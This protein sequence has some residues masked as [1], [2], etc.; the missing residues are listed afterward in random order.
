MS[1]SKQKEILDF[2]QSYPAGQ[3]YILAPKE[4]VIRGFDYYKRGNLQ[5]FEWNEDFSVLSTK[6]RGTRL[7]SVDFS[8]TSSGL[9]HSCSCPTW[10]LYSNC[11]H[12]ICSLITIK[13]LL[14]PT[15]FRIHNQDEGYRMFLLK[16]LYNKPVASPKKE[17]ISGY[18]IVIE[19]TKHISDIYLRRNGNK[20]SEFNLK[21]PYELRHLVLRSYFSAYGKLRDFTQY[22]QKYGNKYPIIFKIKEGETA[23]TFDA[24]GVYSCKT[25][26]D[27]HSDLVKISK[28]CLRN[29]K[30]IDNAVFAE[31][32]IFDTD[33]KSFGIIK[34]K[35]GWMFW[36]DLFEQN[37]P[38]P[39]FNSPLTKGGYRGVK[40]GEGGFSDEI[41]DIDLSSFQMPLENFQDSVITYPSSESD[42][43]ELLILK[44]EG[45]EAKP[46]KPDTAYRLTIVPSDN[47]LFL[48]KAECM[49]GTLKSSTSFQLFR[50]FSLLNKG[51]NPQL[52]A[53]KR[54]VLLCKTFFDMLSV[55]TKTKAEDII[56]Q[57]LA[58]NDFHKYKIKHAARTFLK[59]HLSIFLKDEND[60]L[61]HDTQWLSV[62]VDKK[63]QLSLYKITYELFGWTIFKDIPAF[64]Q[65][66]VNSKDLYEKLPLLYERLKEENIELFFDNKLV[67]TSQWEFSF[68]ACRPSGIDWFEIKPEIRCNGE[69]IDDTSF[70]DMLHRKG[71]IE[72]D[73]C[74]RIM[75]SNSKKILE[76]IST[77]YKTGGISEDRKKEI[78]KVPRLQILD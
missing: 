11:K 27:A 23:F 73:G 16:C 70:L 19:K 62:S 61:L 78:V 18:S 69:L 14:Q 17:E 58:G 24:T 64:D 43:P 53:N 45:I 5:K 6:V 30:V 32:F 29:D 15:T 41:P 36:N 56:K 75:D 13:N 33:T 74:I 59:D 1:D 65:M 42:K 34:S 7:Y 8:L 67:K 35:I 77:I 38:L 12:V 39:P 40:G 20:I 68:D 57:T 47:D 21:V 2:L 71:T 66:I 44:V 63:K 28:T 46:R 3:I 76:V 48:L 22:L 55:D 52:G 25:E 4:Y 9:R 10:S 26:L 37:P 49:L 60:L 51:V 72:K 31:D 50:F 54:K